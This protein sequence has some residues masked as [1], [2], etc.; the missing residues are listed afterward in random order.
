MQLVR[1]RFGTAAVGSSTVAIKG[2]LLCVE[3]IIKFNYISVFNDIWTI[4]N[5][6]K[7]EIDRNEH[8]LLWKW[9]IKVS[10]IIINFMCMV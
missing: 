5:R 1:S 10:L 6:F 3:D 4:T 8:Y 2:L 9:Y 7:L